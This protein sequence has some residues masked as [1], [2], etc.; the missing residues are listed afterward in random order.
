MQSWFPTNT[1]ETEATVVS[2]VDTCTILYF[3][4]AQNH[5][6]FQPLEESVSQEE[7]LCTRDDTLRK[8]SAPSKT[9]FHFLIWSVRP[10]KQL[11][12]VRKYSSLSYALVNRMRGVKLQSIERTWARFCI[13]W[14]GLN[15]V[16]FGQVL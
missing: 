7:V 3:I 5:D 15:R 2:L 14:S 8:V 10:T 9:A 11:S 12:A 16:N 6:F 4:S 13:I 1:N